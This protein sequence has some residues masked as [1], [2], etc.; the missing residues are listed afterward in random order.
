MTSGPGIVITV[1][2][3]NESLV[4]FCK[5]TV[6]HQEKQFK[7]R[8]D[9]AFLKEQVFMEQ[10]YQRDQKIRNLENRIKNVGVNLENI[11]DARLFEKGNHLIYSLDS[12]N[13][14]LNLFKTQIGKL[15]SSLTKQI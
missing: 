1:K 9:S 4:E 8:Q 11:I 5:D 2:D 7:S 13:R 15:E 10:L 3:F 12:A 14:I 6:K